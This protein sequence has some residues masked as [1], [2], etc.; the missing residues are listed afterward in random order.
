MS[1]KLQYASDLHLEFPVNKETMDSN[2]EKAK[3]EKPQLILYVNDRNPTKD[4]KK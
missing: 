1:F 3:H 4:K 2:R